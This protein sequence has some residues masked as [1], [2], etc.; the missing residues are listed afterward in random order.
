MDVRVGMWRKLSTEELMLLN[1]GVG[2]NPWESLGLPVDPTSPSSIFSPE[3]SLEGLTLKLKLQYFGNLMRRTDSLEKTLMLGNIE[4]RR[5]RGPQRMLWLDGITDSMDMSL[6]KLWELVM[7]MEAWHAA[8]HGVSKSRTWLSDETELPS[9]NDEI[10]RKTQFLKNVL[11]QIIILSYWRL[12]EC[13]GHSDLNFYFK[14]FLRLLENINQQHYSL[15][16]FNWLW[17]CTCVCVLHAC[18]LVIFTILGDYQLLLFQICFSPINSHLS[19][20]SITP[21][22]DLSSS[23]FF[24]FFLLCVPF[25]VV[26]LGL[27]TSYWC[28]LQ[29]FNS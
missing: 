29:F 17:V 13:L 3:Y 5:R 11:R 26:C 2:E 15:H 1:C 6:S 9:V 7:D 12:N 16:Y 14:L 24:F 22:R 19:N 25:P 18:W 27:D 23:S 10:A 20:T 28:I 21:M 8:V 4:G